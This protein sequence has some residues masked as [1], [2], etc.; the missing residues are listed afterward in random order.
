[1]SAN[2]LF[3]IVS[4]QGSA[5]QTADYTFN[6]KKTRNVTNQDGGCHHLGCRKTA[7]NVKPDD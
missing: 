6:V 2:I 7:A 4:Q 3:D 5:A 1:L